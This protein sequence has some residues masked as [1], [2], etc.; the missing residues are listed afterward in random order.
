MSTSLS[1]PQRQPVAVRVAATAA[2]TAVVHVLVVAGWVPE[3]TEA[4]IA[5]A[6]DAVGLLVATLWVSRGVTSNAKVVVRVN[7]K[8]DVVAGD[9][10]V[11]D[12]GAPVPVELKAGADRPVVAPVPVRADLVD[13]QIV[14]E[15]G[16]GDDEI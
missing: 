13:T 5:G 7:T 1:L 10:A 9:A 12:T 16:Y 6:V 14:T 15:P 2:V 8:G 4:P 11:V 3:S